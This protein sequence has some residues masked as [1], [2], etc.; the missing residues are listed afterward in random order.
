M[1]IKRAYQFIQW[2]FIELCLRLYAREGKAVG[3]GSEQDG[4]R[5]CLWEA[6]ILEDGA[7]VT[8]SKWTT[9]YIACQTM[10]SGVEKDKAE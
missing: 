5:P 3:F 8:H 10:N 7:T 2:I 1:I 4:R 9:K 6:N